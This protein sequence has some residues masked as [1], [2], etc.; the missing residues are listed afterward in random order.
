VFIILFSGNLQQVS[1]DTQKYSS[2][3]QPLT[4]KNTAVTCSCLVEASLMVPEPQQLACNPT[5]VFLVSPFFGKKWLQKGS[6]II[7]S[8]QHAMDMG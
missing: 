1:Q 2:H 3:Q 7:M 6:Y 8:E 4:F 5:K